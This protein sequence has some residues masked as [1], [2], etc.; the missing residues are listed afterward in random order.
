MN[1]SSVRRVFSP[2]GI[3][4]LIMVAAVGVALWLAYPPWRWERMKEAIRKKYPNVA[5]IDSKDLKEWFDR[6]GDQQ[7]V[8]IDVRP[9]AEYDVSRLHGAR[10]LR[11]SETPAALGFS[12]RDNVPFVVY[13]AIGADSPAV[14]AEFVRLRYTRV[15]VLDGGIFE[16][17]NLGRPLEGPDGPAHKVHPGAPIHAGFLKRSLRAH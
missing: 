10:H 14:V 9:K 15:Q 12:E 4:Q 7:P 6:R 8:V 13:D 16:W 11:P 1:N 2:F 17:A 3:T 5:R